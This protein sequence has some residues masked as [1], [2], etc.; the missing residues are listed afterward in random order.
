MCVPFYSSAGCLPTRQ[1]GNVGFTFR[2][3]ASASFLQILLA[4]CKLY[5]STTTLMRLME[6]KRW[7]LRSLAGKTIFQHTPSIHLHRISV[8]TIGQADRIDKFPINFLGESFG[9]SISELNVS[10]NCI[11]IWP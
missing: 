5:S 11:P 9:E 7:F 8:P 1:L 2:L 6:W 3:Q 10:R 4:S